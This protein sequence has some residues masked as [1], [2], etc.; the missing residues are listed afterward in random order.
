MPPLSGGVLP[1]NLDT[2]PLVQEQIQDSMGRCVFKIFRA[3]IVF[4]GS[5]K[6]KNGWCPFEENT[7]F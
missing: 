5:G 7:H 3:R 6:Y 1:E 4:L 2:L